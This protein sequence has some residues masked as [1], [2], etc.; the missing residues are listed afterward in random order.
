MKE[1]AK[2]PDDIE[3]SQLLPSV[4]QSKELGHQ[5]LVA[6]ANPL[7]LIFFMNQQ[8]NIEH[9][10]Q[11]PQILEPGSFCRQ[12]AKVFVAPEEWITI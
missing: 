1:V 8:V 5:R 3:R 7:D 11:Q 9:P 6:L 12:V 2:T 4:A 10:H